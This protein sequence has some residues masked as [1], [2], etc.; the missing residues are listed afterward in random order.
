MSP[1]SEKVDSGTTAGGTSRSGSV[2]AAAVVGVVVAVL[3]GAVWWRVGRSSSS[4]EHV[5]VIGDSVTYASSPA[6]FER[7]DGRADVSIT[8]RPFYRS[9]DLVEPFEEAIAARDEAGEGLDRAIVLAGY[10][11]VIRDDRDPAGLPKLLD[12]AQRFDCAVWLTLPTRP[13]GRPSGRADFPTGEATDWNERVR[14]E[15]VSRP[16]V[17]VSDEW[18]R[19][20]EAPG[21][22]RLL[23]DDGV[24]PVRA[25][26][27]ALAASMSRALADECDG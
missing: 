25:G 6:I 26:H 2:V 5:V 14:R 27:L 21:G 20:V 17:R 18:Q 19:T 7:F 4:V 23:Q 24:H 13:G 8:S 11:D 1:A 9:I 12:Q 10:N 15:A 3:A 22:E 16:H